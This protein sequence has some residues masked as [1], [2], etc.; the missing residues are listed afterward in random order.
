MKISILWKPSA[1][2]SSLLQ[3]LFVL[4]AAVVAES[5]ILFPEKLSFA[6]IAGRKEGRKDS[7]L[8]KTICFTFFAPPFVSAEDE[9]EE[10]YKIAK[11]KKK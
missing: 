11:G 5:K 8:E 4:F 2:E 1:I 10:E 6:L 3:N 9:V 7:K